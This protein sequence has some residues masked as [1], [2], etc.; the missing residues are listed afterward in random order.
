[1]SAAHDEHV[2]PVAPERLERDRRRLG[3]RAGCLRRSAH[4]VP[5]SIGSRAS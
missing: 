2:E 3:E 5:M 1:M 4:G